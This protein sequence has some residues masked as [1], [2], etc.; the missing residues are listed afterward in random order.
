MTSEPATNTTW[1]A[2]WN[3]GQRSLLATLCLAT[4]LHAAN[5][6]LAATTLPAAIA[7]IGGGA[8]INWAFMLYQLGSIVAGAATALLVTRLGIRRA[9]IAAALIYG[10]GSVVCA[11]APEMAVFLAGRALQG[12]GGGWSIALVF[13]AVSRFFPDNMVPRLMALIS[14]FWSLSAFSGPLIGGIFSSLGIWRMAYWSFAFQPLILIG[15]V[16]M[17]VARDAPGDTAA[18]RAV[19]KANFPA[20][21]LTVLAAAIL[22]IAWAGAEVNRTA[23]PLYAAAGLALLVLFF[24][25]DQ[26]AGATRMFPPRP[27]HPGHLAGVGLLMV[28]CISA[29]SM[30]FLVYGP[31]LL[32][33]LHGV[34]PLTAGFIVAA[35][36]VFWGVAAFICSGA[37][38]RR[39]VYLIR[40]GLCIIVACL[41]AFAFVVPAGPVAGILLLTSATGVGFGMMWGFVIRRIAT[42][43]EPA[44]RDRTASAMPTTQQMGFAIGAAATGIIAN[45]AG[46][47][48]S[49]SLE[50]LRGVSFWVFASF[51]PVAV[52][53]L[54][55][56][57]R[58]T[59]MKMPARTVD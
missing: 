26:R 55:M 27:L 57:W 50:E 49:A 25:L 19:E 20:R 41:G 23:S 14:V 5:S 31:Y 4:W 17:T 16:M 34:S 40:I 28:I 24:R 8:Y 36:S 30:S 45:A 39:E 3:S 56:G 9:M 1:Q 46:F 13:I 2:V 37:D 53:A 38:A 10:I 32:E 43:A 59:A 48:D 58:M 29:A 33:R 11:S 42:S 52:V 47:G 7:E 51:V 12:Y 15:A 18:G 44:E 6:M 35:E 21:R 54:I 22:S